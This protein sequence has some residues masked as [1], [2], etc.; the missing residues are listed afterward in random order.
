MKQLR[1]LIVV[2][3]TS[4]I[5]LAS[6][7]CSLRQHKEEKP[8]YVFCHANSECE[9]PQVCNKEIGYWR[10][11]YA[12]ADAGVCIE[13]AVASCPNGYELSGGYNPRTGWNT[14]FCASGPIYCHSDQECKPDKCDKHT[15]TFIPSSAG[16]GAGVCMAGN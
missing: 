7:S 8:E 10:P 3:I 1:G 16:Q 4:A 13:A 14:S 11:P 12:P 2:T 5:L 6:S 9:P 15:D